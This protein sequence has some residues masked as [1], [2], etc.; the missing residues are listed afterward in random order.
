MSQGSVTGSG[1][2]GKEE[3]KA[4][5]VVPPPISASSEENDRREDGKRKKKRKKVYIA[6]DFKHAQPLLKKQSLLPVFR[7]RKWFA[8]HQELAKLERDDPRPQQRAELRAAK[9]AAVERGDLPIKPKK[10]ACASR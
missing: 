8:R 2:E 9:Q 7:S 6:S 3:S 1:A 5:A 10:K 4:E